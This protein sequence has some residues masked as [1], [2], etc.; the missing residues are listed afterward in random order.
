MLLYLLLKIGKH[1]LLYSIGNHQIV[2]LQCVGTGD[3]H[4]MLFHTRLLELWIQKQS[5][6][7]ATL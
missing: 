1:Y 2:R 7:G 6:V 3:G 4:T 5:Q